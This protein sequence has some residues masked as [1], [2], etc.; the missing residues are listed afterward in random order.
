[1]N[2]FAE[3]IYNIRK[4]RHEYAPETVNNFRDNIHDDIDENFDEYAEAWQQFIN[5]K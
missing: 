5:I 2:E 4:I 3:H 1:M